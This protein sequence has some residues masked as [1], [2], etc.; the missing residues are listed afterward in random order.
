MVGGAVHGDRRRTSIWRKRL[1]GVC[2]ILSDRSPQDISREKAGWA[3]QVSL[4]GP[5]QMAGAGAGTLRVGAASEHT[6]SNCAPVLC[7]PPD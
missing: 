1:R 6:V 3:C 7:K 5:Q 4:R 2:F